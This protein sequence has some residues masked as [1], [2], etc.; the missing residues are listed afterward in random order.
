M[1]QYAPSRW[2]VTFTTLWFGQLVSLLGNNLT[3][4]ALGVWV[5]KRNGSVTQFALIS[6]FVV[7]PGTLLSPIAGAFVDKYDRRWIMILGDAAAGLS[8]GTLAL[9]LYGGHLEVWHIY[10]ALTVSSLSQAFQAPAFLASA[11]LLAPKRHLGRVSGMMQLNEGVSQLVAPMLAGLMMMKIG[12]WSILAI[13]FGTFV[14]A[15]ATQVV[16]R[17]PKLPAK[18]GPAAPKESLRARTAFGWNYVRARP[19]LLALLVFFATGNMIFGFLQTLLT[20]LVLSFADAATLGTALSAAGLGLLAGSLISSIWGGPKKKVIGV[21]T[22]TF[23]QGLVLLL[24]GL[25]PNIYLVATGCFLFLLCDPIAFTANQ[26]IWLSKVAP[27]V[28]GRVLA[29]RRMVARSFLPLAFVLAGPLADRVFEPLMAKGGALSSTFGS[30]MG[31]GPGRGIGLL[32]AIL[33]ITLLL[34]V[35]VA[36]FYGPLQRIERELPDPV[37]PPVREPI[38][39]SIGLG[40]QVESP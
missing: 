37:K 20:P 36:S 35:T 6:L 13:D 38:A 39:E 12:I 17:V 18:I 33:G 27:E 29:I 7:L 40:I 9:L 11:A 8:M 34:M 32:F 16:A 30:V 28:Q 25:K 5:Y 10:V 21:L 22:L 14:F 4:F 1:T 26:V 31:V 24:A 15:V 19:G 23:V 3:A 2:M